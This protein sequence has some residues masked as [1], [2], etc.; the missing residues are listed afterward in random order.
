M[1]VCSCTVH[2]DKCNNYTVVTVDMS[3]TVVQL[4]QYS[5]LQSADNY[6]KLTVYMSVTLDNCR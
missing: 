4:V 1:Y 2:V 5:Y 3:V 6:T